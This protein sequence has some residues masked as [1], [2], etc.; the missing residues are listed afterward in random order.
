MA[1][2]DNDNY[3]EGVDFEWVQGNNDENSGFKTRRFF[4]K[5]EKAKMNAP[6]PAA[7]KAAAPK[8]AAPKLKGITTEKI[9][10][11]A[12]DPAVRPA[13]KASGMPE[14]L[15]NE[16]KRRTGI[17]KGQGQGQAKSTKASNYV[18]PEK[19]DTSGA[20]GVSKYRKNM[21]MVDRIMQAAGNAG[22]AVG[23]AIGSGGMAKGG[24]VKEGTAKD[25]REDKAM[26]KK[27]GMTMKQ[28]EAS[29][30]DKKHDAPKKMAMGGAVKKMNYGGGMKTGGTVR[31]AGAAIRGKRFTGLC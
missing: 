23:R 26:A 18:R 28:H 30:A 8:K 25:M 21:S 4:T 10:V 29:A 19:T 31:G 7:P 5:A 22:T 12:L 15:G 9:T 27:S 20:L 16:V 2:G 1:Q 14:S 11:K 6:K 13:G 17:G 3:K 24:M